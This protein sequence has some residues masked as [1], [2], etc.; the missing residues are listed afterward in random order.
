[1]KVRFKKQYTSLKESISYELEDTGLHSTEEGLCRNLKLLGFVP[2][3]MLEEADENDIPA[4][5]VLVI[6]NINIKK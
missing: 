5:D 2:D 3:Y 4:I 1:M 6:I